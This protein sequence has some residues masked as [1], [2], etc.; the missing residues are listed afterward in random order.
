MPDLKGR[1]DELNSD[2]VSVVWLRRTVNALKTA[3]FRFANTMK[4]QMID[5]ALAAVRDVI[6][7]HIGSVLESFWSLF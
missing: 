1:L 6:K 3:S 7:H 4:E 2:T 5:G